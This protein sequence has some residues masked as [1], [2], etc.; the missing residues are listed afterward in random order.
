MS[1]VVRDEL[2]EFN[3]TQGRVIIDS[4]LEDGSEAYTELRGPDCRRL[5]IMHASKHGLAS[6]GTSGNVQTYPVD[7]AGN[8][9]VDTK[10]QKIA[11]FRAEVPVTRKIV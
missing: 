6:P 5:A 7:P 1:L 11:A 3:D 10:T 8:E 2:C 4:T 9:V